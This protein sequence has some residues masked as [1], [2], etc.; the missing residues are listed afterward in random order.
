VR[1]RARARVRISDTYWEG[2]PS[3]TTRLQSE[4]YVIAMLEFEKRMHSYT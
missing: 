1:A 2:D 3:L 4:S